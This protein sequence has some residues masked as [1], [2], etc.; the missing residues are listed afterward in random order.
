[1]TNFR[2]YK[3]NISSFKS[4]ST[5]SMIFRHIFLLSI[6]TLT[7]L[8]MARE[9]RY[10]GVYYGSYAKDS[11]RISISLDL[12]IDGI[13][14][15]DIKMINTNTLKNY[16]MEFHLI[17]LQ[18]EGKWFVERG[19]LFLSEKTK[20]TICDEGQTSYYRNFTVISP[21]LRKKNQSICNRFYIKTPTVKCN[22][23]E[24]KSREYYSCYEFTRLANDSLALE[25]MIGADF[26]EQI[27]DGNGT[28]VVKK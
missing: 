8:A 2:W 9:N 20:D 17:P 24:M 11:C 16:H 21:A 19:V 14:S 25:L 10:A 26:Y 27:W 7:G 23:Y 18:T 3:H 6:M 5:I 1:M 4:L 12:K 22:G 13:Y 28:F 15:L